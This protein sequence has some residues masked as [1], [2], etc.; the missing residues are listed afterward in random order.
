[1]HHIQGSDREQLTL[2]PEALDE[3]I[4]EDNPVRF[5]DAFVET[6]DFGGLGFLHAM[7]QETGRPPYHPA[8]LLKLYVYG[9][10][11]RIR[12]SRRL[13]TESGRNLELMWLLKRLTPDFKTIA[14]FRRDNRQ[15]IRQVSR[16]FT[17]FCRR[18]DLFGG[19]LVAIDGSKFKAQNSKGRNF[20]Q[21]KLKRQIKDLDKK[22]DDYLEELD[23]ADEEEKDVP[24]KPNADQLREKIEAMKRRQAERRQL[25]EQMRQS[26]Q[27]QI[28]L[29]DPDSR[30]MPVGGGEATVVGFNVQ[31][32]VDS[33][34]KL[35]VDHE[36]TT[37]VTDRGLLSA[38]AERAKQALGVAEID[39][40]ADKGYYNGQEVKACLEE[41][42]TPYIPKANTSANR[43]RGLFTKEDFRY[44]PD[45][46]DYGCP[47]GQALTYRF[48]T[49]EQEREI[50]YYSN[51][52]ACRECGLKPQC[53]RNKGGRRIT[54]W[55]D[56]HLLEAMQ[57]RVQAEPEKVGLRK[58]LAEHPFGT[59]K[60]SWNQG[61]FLMRGL[62]K[63]RAEMALTV[64][65]Y[66]LKRVIRIL[67]VPRMIEA[68]G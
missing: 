48:T 24:D 47:A 27:S 4:A 36:V 60:H 12:S 64:M 38:M 18:L 34:Y 19:E 5:L 39:V 50:R 40:I 28:S 16:E 58:Q 10:L 1:M 32:S 63:V 54:R 43:K 8:D 41:D 31:L 11:N 17:L 29:T 3:Y 25:E 9:Y 15:A 13:E 23:Q 22:I 55:V 67:G 46:D 52:A 20:T 33:K 37:D 65:A 57:A 49:V 21:R 7:L 2:F 59:I 53:T 51:P 61:Y 56:E 26:G 44:D 45:Q 62:E 14:D 66:D 6:L 30:S 35:I 68:L 42:I